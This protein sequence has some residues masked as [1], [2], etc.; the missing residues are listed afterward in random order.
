[1]CRGMKGRTVVFE[2]FGLWRHPLGVRVGMRRRFGVGCA[3]RVARRRPPVGAH[4]LC[5]QDPTAT[6]P[7]DGTSRPRAVARMARFSRPFEA[8]KR[9][10]HDTFQAP[11][12]S[13]PS[14]ATLGSW[15]SLWRCEAG[16]Q[17]WSRDTTPVRS[18]SP[19]AS[20][21]AR[22]AQVASPSRS[23]DSRLANGR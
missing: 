21:R 7:G 20:E 11:R 2:Q 14:R 23:A 13:I 5:S 22:S 18:M 1:M 3:R 4:V 10:G 8:S 15:G 19:V 6:G 17:P 16:R 9:P 12:H